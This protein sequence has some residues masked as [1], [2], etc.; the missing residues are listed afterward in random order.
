MTF[1]NPWMLAV[2]APLV[3]VAAWRLLRRGRKAGV[4]FSAFSRI[5]PGAAGFR[6]KVAAATP[7]ILLAGLALLVVAA[8]RPRTPLAR[9]SAHHC[10]TFCSNGWAALRKPKYTCGHT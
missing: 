7:F 3:A 6:A 2:F 8:A 4:R 9:G 5:P 10:A 1:A